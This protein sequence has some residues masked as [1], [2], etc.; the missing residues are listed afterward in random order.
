MRTVRLA[1]VLSLFVASFQAIAQERA[2]TP[3]APAAAPS[4]EQIEQLIRQLGDE[5]FDKREAANKALTTIGSRARVALERAT[6]SDDAEIAMRAKLILEG[7]PKLT[8]TIVDALGQ[9]IPLASVTLQFTRQPPSDL[10][11]LPPMAS[12]SEE[13]GRIGIPEVP[14]SE[15]TAPPGIPAPPSHLRLIAII[16]HDDYG[17]ARVEVD[18]VDRAGGTT[19]LLLPLVKRGTEAYER[20][21]KGEVV[22]A[23]GTPLGG[24]AINC[25]D[26]RTPGEGLIEGRFPRGEALSGADGR[27]TYY[28][29][30]SQQRESERGVL[31]PANSRFQ[32]QI[33]VPGDDSFFPWSGR[34]ANLQLAR[35]ELPRAT[36]MHRFRFEATGG[37]FVSDP[38]V[39]QNT[40]VQLDRMDKGERYL[41]DLG[42]AAVQTGRRLIPGTYQAQSFLNGKTIQYL[43]L[44]VTA[45]SP[46]ELTFQLPH[47]VTFRG[48]VVG[49]TSGEPIA[50]AIVVGWSSTSRN[51]LALLTA[52]DWAMLKD[53][54]SNP[55]LD[56]PAITR[57]RAFYGVHALVRADGDGRFAITQQPGQEFYGILAF[58][59]DAVP[60]RVS[61]GGLKPNEKHEVDVGEFPLYP[62]ARVVVRPVFEGDR[63]AV[64]PRWYPAADGQPEWFPKFKATFDGPSSREFECAHWLTM[65]EPQP[66][67]VPAGLK[68]SLAF[69]TPY[70][71]KWDDAIVEGLQLDTNE[72]KNIGD[73]TFAA[74]LPVAVR[75]VDRQGKPI[76]GIP[77]RQ[78]YARDNAWSVAH[79]TDKEGLARFH[80]PRK[81][82]GK[83]W[84]SDLPGTQEARSAENLYAKFTLEDAAPPEPIATITLTDEQAE[85][86]LGKQ[87]Q[88]P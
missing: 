31:I 39:L 7:L 61:V 28:L 29:P 6:K 3:V 66:V 15:M 81:T 82:S 32:L 86:L 54:P 53:T 78:M 80:F 69:E 26:I 14:K 49:G 52:E 20:A 68:L 62:A 88:A 9:P 38:G 57:L 76:E 72:I 77:V 36:R 59:P 55:P 56:H 19:T 8:H 10:P 43:P 18:P 74:N 24:A 12:F 65:N 47:P 79:N 83:F 25:S 5:D 50:G 30:P 23:D 45:D 60:Y 64:C 42:N 84:V 4:A 67:F 41:T 37:G 16:A 75:V 44:A 48:T 51:N 87:Q 63:L 35:I 11:V 34:Y 1:A 27:F 58:A 22:A 13:D 40:R 2:P 21:L 46:E 17:M 71:D 85:L 70:D 73:V 33:T